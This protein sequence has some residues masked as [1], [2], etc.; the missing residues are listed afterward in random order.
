MTLNESFH[1]KFFV[2]KFEEC[3][4]NLPLLFDN[5]TFWLIKIDTNF[6]SKTLL[7]IFKYYKELRIVLDCS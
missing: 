1:R 5:L 6:V 2:I 7:E 3:I 4:L